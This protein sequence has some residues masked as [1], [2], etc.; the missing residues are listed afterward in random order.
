MKRAYALDVLCCPRC[1]GPMRLIAVI[2][3]ELVARR[4]LEHLGLPARAPPR[5]RRS[6]PAQDH[7]P[8]LVADPEPVEAFD[9]VDPLPSYESC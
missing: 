4:I 6:R 7:L 9:G 1:K 8:G 2:D 5:G 3:N